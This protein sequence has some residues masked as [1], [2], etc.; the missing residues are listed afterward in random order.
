MTDD[1]TTDGGPTPLW[2]RLLVGAVLAVVVGSVAST[3]IWPA[4]N[5]ATTRDDRHG[6]APLVLTHDVAEIAAAARK[7]A[8]SL[9]RFRVHEHGGAAL[10][11]TATTRVLGFVDDLQLHLERQADGTTHV[12]VTSASRVGQLDFGQNARNIRELFA[13]LQRHLPATSPP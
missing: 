12:H 4:T 10:T 11:M 9:D 8:A 7:A 5:K 13:E 1:A 2:R 3:L 6:L